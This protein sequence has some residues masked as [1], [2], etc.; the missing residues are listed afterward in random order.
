MSLSDYGTSIVRTVVPYLVGF[1]V[2]QGAK[3]G[4]DIDAA[5]VTPIV[6]VVVGTVYYAVVRKI[7]ETK[8]G[9]GKLLGKAA[10]PVYGNGGE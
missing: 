5:E 9:V 1:V 3:R 2:A 4:L 10:E 6:T 7:E 8:P